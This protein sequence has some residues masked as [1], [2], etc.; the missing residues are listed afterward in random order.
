VEELVGAQLAARVRDTAIAI[1][2]FA[3]EHARRRGII[4]ADTKFEFGVDEA[5]QL[6]LIDEVLTPDSSRFWPADT[7]RVGTSPPSFDKQFVRDYLETLD[8]N[9]KAPGPSLPPDIIART[10][11][12]YGEALERLT[13]G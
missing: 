8:W 7:Y 13:G 10:S 9:K 2:N 3:A 5:G 12:K 11:E 1:Y 4:I 6:T